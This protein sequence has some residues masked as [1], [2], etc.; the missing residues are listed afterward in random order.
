[1][2][3]CMYVCMTIVSLKFL[4][5]VIFVKGLPVRT[6][7]TFDDITVCLFCWDILIF[8]KNLF[9]KIFSSFI[10]RRQPERFCTVVIHIPTWYMKTSRALYY[11]FFLILKLA[12]TLF[13]WTSVIFITCNEVPPERNN[14][15]GKY[16]PWGPPLIPFTSSTTYM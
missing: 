5:I 10:N 8:D 14:Y 3:V 7:L 12:W 1:M 16:V 11:Q 2:Y 4:F 13:I 9:C 6:Y 15:E